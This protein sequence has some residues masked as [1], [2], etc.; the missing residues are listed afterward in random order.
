MMREIKFRV[1]EEDC[2]FMNDCVQ[3]VIM[4]DERTFEVTEGFGWKMVPEKHVM[5]FTGLHDKNGKWIYEGD[6]VRLSSDNGIDYNAM[7][8]FKNGA[9]CAIDGTEDDYSIRRYGLMRFELQIEIIGNIY[10]NPEL[11]EE[12]K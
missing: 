1:W 5:Q 4:D 2:N 9:F 10:E 3:I 7:I 6:I 8:V 11:L 12:L